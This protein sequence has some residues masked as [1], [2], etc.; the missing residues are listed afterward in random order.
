MHLG[1][2]VFDAVVKF[3]KLRLLGFFEWV[4]SIH[5]CNEH[6]VSIGL[7]IAEICIKEW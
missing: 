6:G 5:N 3:G 4:E 7:L 2:D 1:F